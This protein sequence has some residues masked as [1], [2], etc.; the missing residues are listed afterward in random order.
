MGFLG[1]ARLDACREDGTEGERRSVRTE[2][3]RQRISI[4]DERHVRFRQCRLLPDL[5]AERPNDATELSITDLTVK[6]KSTVG[7][8][9]QIMVG[10]SS[11]PHEPRLESRFSEN[12]FQTRKMNP[13][14]IVSCYSSWPA[15]EYFQG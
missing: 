9:G 2:L 11:S 7:S 1:S 6:V 3:H 10:K 14:G 4:G 12:Q 15:G 13:C 5:D 8:G